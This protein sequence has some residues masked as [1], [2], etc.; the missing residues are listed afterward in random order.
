M[1]SKLKIS[2]P[3]STKQNLHIYFEN[4]K[5]K[6]VPKEWIPFINSKTPH[7]MDKNHDEDP[8]IP[9]HLIRKKSFFSRNEK[10]E[11]P[12]DLKAINSN[13]HWVQD[14]LTYSILSLHD[15]DMEDK[16][17][18]KLLPFAEGESGDQYVLLKGKADISKYPFL[19]NTNLC[20][21][22]LL[23][24]DK[25][26]HERLQ[27]IQ[28][29]IEL[30]RHICKATEHKGLRHVVPLIAAGK[31][32]Y[33]SLREDVRID[34][35]IEA[36]KAD[37]LADEWKQLKYE[38]W[39][40]TPFVEYDFSQ[41]IQLI[42]E[43][44]GVFPKNVMAL[45]F[46]QILKGIE[47]LHSIHVIHR[48]IRPENVMITH[49]GIVKLVEFEQ[50]IRLEQIKDDNRTG[51]ET[52]YSSCKYLYSFAN[53]FTGTL[54]YMAPECVKEDDY[55]FA[56]DIWSFGVLVHECITGHPLY[57]E[58][59]PEDAILELKNI[60]ETPVLD[61]KFKETS[62]G[63][64]RNFR[65]RCLT[66]DQD[67]RPT[68][69]TLL[70]HKF[71]RAQNKNSMTDFKNILHKLGNSKTELESDFKELFATS[72]HSSGAFKRESKLSRS[73]RHFD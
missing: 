36:V 73:S 50:A 68:A 43:G 71:L 11:S 52:N 55:Q 5:L 46:I 31:I 22:R 18:Y 29:E 34:T 17:A 62:D 42:M 51:L 66:V 19:F 56:V 59:S 67:L 69:M 9:A 47:Y 24:I 13:L 6:G 27:T 40:I 28:E 64:C 3:T 30:Y 38:I 16:D 61:D 14:T 53:T 25:R 23:V 21:K 2:S 70:K 12:L 44:N 33:T 41:F 7:L 8:E 57:T 49:N 15:L 65:K 4:G 37:S 58:G 63:F 35:D 10:S 32:N 26:S 20:V 72:H 1:N 45:V 60:K 39:I 48:D 54:F